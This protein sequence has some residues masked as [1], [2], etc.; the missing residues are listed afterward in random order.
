MNYRHID[1]AGNFADIVKHLVLISILAQL[2]KKAKPFAVLDAFS[3]LGLYDLNSEA[4]SKTLESD[5][6]IN[7]LLQ[8]TD[9][10]P[11]L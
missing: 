8:A 6:G 5:T 9:P 10:I 11:Q 3:G 1:H 2:K 4:A 7:K